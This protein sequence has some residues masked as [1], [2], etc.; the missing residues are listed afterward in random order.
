[1][2][3]IGT[4]AALAALAQEHRLQAYR[5]LVQAGPEGL[6]AGEIAA[7]LGMPPN[8]L[9]FHL[10]RLRNADLV[11]FQRRGRSLI[12]AAR[13]DTMNGLI[14]YLTENC[15]RGQPELCEP[16]CSTPK[17]RTAKRSKETV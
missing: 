13:Y 4:L 16:I 12:Y 17:K 7:A 8:T 5:L 15:C 11:A 1:V 9:S 14:G 6:A 2:E 10:D 3:T